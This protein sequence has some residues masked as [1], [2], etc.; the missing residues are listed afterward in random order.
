VALMARYFPTVPIGDTLEPF[1][2]PPSIDKAR[3]VPGYAPQHT[4]R[5]QT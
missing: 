3:A 2:T 4:R 1:G 5:V